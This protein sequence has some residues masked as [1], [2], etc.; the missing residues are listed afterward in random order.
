MIGLDTDRT[1]AALLQRA[2]AT[3]EAAGVETARQDAEWLLASLLGVERFALYLDPGRRLS[4]PRVARYLA[5]VERR[6]ARE[7]LQYLL[8]W[9]D[10]HGVRLSVTSDVLV[11]RPETEGL[12]EWALEVLGGR[13]DPGVADLGTG[14]GAIACAIASAR[15]DADVLAVEVS[16]GALAVASRNVR[17]LGLA[18]RV[19]LLAGDLFAPL[20]SLSASLDLVVANPPY[21]LSAVIP[22]LPPEV[23][24]HEPRAALD[25]GPDG[26]AVL[27]RIVAGAPRVLKTGGWLL[28]EIGEEQAGPLASLMAAEG[29]SGIRARLDANGVERYI[30]GRWDPAETT[31]AGCASG[32]ARREGC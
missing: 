23:S 17:E 10:F 9:E 2:I 18:S 12:V 5:T 8:G 1:V 7:P 25:G 3:L 24:R 31:L 22:S 30:G 19:R 20:G 15:P 21:L 13:P 14:S 4:A 16:A 11:P 6:A 26:M 29:F 28:M 32:A 27:R